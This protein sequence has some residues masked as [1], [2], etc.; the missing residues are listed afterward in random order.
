MIK[1]I[2][3]D[4]DGTLLRS[5]G[6]FPNEFPLILDSLLNKNI[7]FSVASGRQYFTLKDNMAGFEDKITFIAENGAFIVKDGK[8]LFAKTLDRD[9]LSKVVDDAKKVP[10][11]KLVLCGKKSAYVLDKSSAF[12][13]EVEKY[14]HKSAVVNSLDEI[15]DEFF[16]IAICDYKG[17]AN[18]SNV[19]LSPKWGKL[20]QLT[21]SGDIWL[22]IGRNDVNKG[23]AI[24]FLQDKFNINENETMAFGD[25]YNDVSMLQS[26]Y[27]SYVMENAPD[28]VKKHGRFIAKSNDESGVI[29]VIKN[30]VLELG[31]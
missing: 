20:F 7:M 4:M 31:A 9:M 17:S 15:D 2:A 1:L 19:L 28:G 25:Y 13:E 5:N 27:H 24:K 14:Y 12:I 21:V 26:V 10:D 22:D 16:K 18:N 30:K 6:E 11:C 23:T 8:E 3:T 29:Q